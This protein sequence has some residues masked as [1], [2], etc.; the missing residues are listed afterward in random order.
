M[1]VKRFQHGAAGP[2]V[3]PV[4]K[5][6]IAF[7]DAELR[8]GQTHSLSDEYPSLFGEY[9]GGDSFYIESRGEVASHAAFLIREFRNGDRRLKVGLVGSVTTASAFRGQGMAKAVLAETIGELKRQGCILAL[10]WSGQPEFYRLMGFFRAG[11]ELDLRFSAASVPAV[12]G[13][14]VEY[15]PVRHAH[16]VWRLYQ[17][18]DVRVDRSL[19]E[20]KTLLRIPKAR[21]F[22]TEREGKV[23]SYVA[24]NKGADFTDYIHEWGGE[25]DELRRNVA[26]VQRSVFADRALTLIAPYHY[27]MEGLRQIAE[28]SWEGVLG[29]VKVLDRGKLLA[30]YRDYLREC[31]PDAKWERD[32]AV[33][34]GDQRMETASDE[35]LL[36][37]VL[38][39]EGAFTHPALPFFLW[40]FDSI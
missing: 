12:S 5:R 23:T 37:T 36:K 24:I 15:D 33:F 28:K 3:L 6:L 7:L 16:L 39:G 18:H 10:L 32:E 30:L 35:G 14:A 31:R 34:F 11:R 4:R 21:V 19:E 8:A 2:D 26:W 22:V 40:G 17:K 9:P 27:R 1:V 25:P 38:G 13:E 29:L 20:Q